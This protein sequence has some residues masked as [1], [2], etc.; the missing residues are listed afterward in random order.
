MWMS[1]VLITVDRLSARQSGLSDIAAGI[2]RMDDSSVLNVDEHHHVIEAS[3]PAHELPK[4][5]E[6]AGVCY[7]RCVFNY[8]V[9]EPKPTKAA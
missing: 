6:M 8:F 1:N 4:V 7:V 3:V 2:G 9:N 5:R